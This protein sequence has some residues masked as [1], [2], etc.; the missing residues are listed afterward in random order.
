MGNKTMSLATTIAT[1]ICSLLACHPKSTLR[2]KELLIKLRD[3]AQTP[4]GKEEVNKLLG[5]DQELRCCTTTFLSLKVVDQESSLVQHYLSDEQLKNETHRRQLDDLILNRTSY[6]DF[7]QGNSG[8]EFRME[9]FGKRKEQQLSKDEL[10]VL[11][12]NLCLAARDSVL[13]GDSI[14]LWKK[15]ETLL[16]NHKRRLMGR[17]E[18]FKEG[19]DSRLSNAEK[20]YQSTLDQVVVPMAV[21][22]KHRFV[23][24]PCSKVSRYNGQTS[25]EEN[26]NRS[27]DICIEQPVEGLSSSEGGQASAKEDHNNRLSI[28][29]IEQPVEAATS[30][31]EVTVSAPSNPYRPTI[32]E[33]ERIFRQ[34][35]ARRG[36]Q[37]A[38]AA[39]TETHSTASAFYVNR[40]HF[41]QVPVS[42]SMQLYARNARNRK[43]VE[44]AI[45]ISSNNLSANEKSAALLTYISK[46]YP[47]GFDLFMK[48]YNVKGAY[49]HPT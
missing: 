25:A 10:L 13:L 8:K 4:K 30:E 23:S 28:I 44:K 5:R 1:F 32:E 7:L 38:F 34:E 31:E 6:N 37:A 3:L 15:S 26:D 27:S 22:R 14:K 46:T 47:G 17:F 48:Q 20:P 2:K 24:L 21:K 41:V 19:S 18:A 45:Q 11:S 39:M 16:R 40:K 29:C 42:S 43:W 49:A 33:R 12:I 36:L 9:W 35:I